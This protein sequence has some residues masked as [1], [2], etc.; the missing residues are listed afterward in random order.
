MSM[1]L[2]EY[3]I[4]TRS[5]ATKVNECDISVWS[6]TTKEFL[7]AVFESFYYDYD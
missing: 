7:K 5:F 2:N 6:I 3:D 1:L 4:S